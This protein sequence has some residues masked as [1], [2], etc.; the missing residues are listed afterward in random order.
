MNGINVNQEVTLYPDCAV[1][2]LV[3]K[4]KI[5]KQLELSREVIH[6]N[7]AEEDAKFK[8]FKGFRLKKKL[9]QTKNVRFFIY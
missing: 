7:L 1:T 9:P 2:T 8:F 3:F 4:Y 5:E 6:I